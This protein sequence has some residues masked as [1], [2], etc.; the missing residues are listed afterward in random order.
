MR[1]R[2]EAG[3]RRTEEGTPASCLCPPLFDHFLY[4]VAFKNEL[5]KRAGD[6]PPRPQDFC[7]TR[8]RVWQS[9]APRGAWRSAQ[10]SSLGATAAPL[11]NGPAMAKLGATRTFFVIHWRHLERKLVSGR[12][13]R[14]LEPDG[15]TI[16][17]RIS[18]CL[19]HL[20][21]IISNPPTVCK[22]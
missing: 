1:Q 17:R 2:T 4:R 8:K 20:L 19:R 16:L 21:V 13:C 10:R 18:C 22:I 9:A 6:F 14:T 11:L 7:H 15:V 5:T 3:R 12:L